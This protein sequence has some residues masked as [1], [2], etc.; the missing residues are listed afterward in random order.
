MEILYEAVWKKE[1][2]TYIFL[3]ESKL[4]APIHTPKHVMQA[5]YMKTYKW[6]CTYS[7]TKMNCHEIEGKQVSTQLTGN[8][9][10]PLTNV[11]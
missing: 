8:V 7:Y 1:T 2:T 6:D 10:R 9:P 11:L 3:E 4:K 5:D